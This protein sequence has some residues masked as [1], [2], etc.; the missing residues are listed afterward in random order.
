MNIIIDITDYLSEDEIKEECKWAIRGSIHEMFCKNESDINRL[1]SN[2][3]YEF[4][5]EAVSKA[6]G[7]DSEKTIAE[8]VTELAKDSSAIKYEMWR[9]KDAW[10][11]I[12]SPAIK[13]LYEAIE[14]NKWL[15]RDC[16][17]KAIMDF[18][19]PNVRDAMYDIACEII[20]EKLFGKN[21]NT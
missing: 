16:I 18:E 13:I 3:G 15:M 12:E 2:L 19:F 1:I 10:D 20:S 7:K 21:E 5:F 4:I 11:K 9:K 17:Q 14:D 6:I 8:K